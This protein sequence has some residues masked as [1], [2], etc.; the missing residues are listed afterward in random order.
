MPLA[1]PD[2]VKVLAR[3]SMLYQTA[4][5]RGALAKAPRK[6][7]E[8]EVSPMGMIGGV[9]VGMQMPGRAESKLQCLARP[10]WYACIAIC[11]GLELSLRSCLEAA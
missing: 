2:L 3:R 8:E 1:I 11:A 4:E 6:L 5:R 10:G 7:L 9:P